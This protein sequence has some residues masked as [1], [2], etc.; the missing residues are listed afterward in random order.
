MASL[1]PHA[2]VKG[3]TLSVA[4]ISCLSVPGKVFTHI[5]LS[6]EYYYLCSQVAS[7][8]KMGKNKVV[9]QS[10]V[11]DVKDMSRLK[12]YF[13]LVCIINKQCLIKYT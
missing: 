13:F 11:R 1:C 3:L 8:G 2:R 4:T 10:K 12:M 9:G 6:S 5:L 7:T